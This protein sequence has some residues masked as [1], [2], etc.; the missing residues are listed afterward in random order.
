MR[1]KRDGKISLLFLLCFSAFGYAQIL[2][3]E[4]YSIKDGL[5]SNWITSIFQDS[6]GY[7]WIGGD[8]G[9]SVYDG[10]SFKT[11][12]V[13]DGLPIGFVW[14]FAE[15]RQSPGTIYVGTN[16]GGLSKLVN[17]KF[18]STL[19]KPQPSSAEI[20]HHNAVH[21]IFEDDEGR[22]WCG[23]NRG[24]YHIRGDSVSFF[25]ASH[26]SGGVLFIVQAPDGRI[27]FNAG[28]NLYTYSAKAQ[29]VE[30]YELNI[31]VAYFSS[32]FADDDRSVWIG[33]SRGIIYK[34]RDDRI[35]ASRQA[36]QSAIESI[37]GDREGFL[38]ITTHAGLLKIAKTDFAKG[39]FTHYTADNGLP[40]NVLEASF[41]DRENNLWL[42]SRRAGLHKL[43][44]RNLTTFPF[45]GVN[46]VPDVLNQTAATDAQNHL[47]VATEKGLWEIW[48]NRNGSWEKF[49]HLLPELAAR[50][51]KKSFNYHNS[52]AISKDGLLW[53][54]THGG[55]LAGYKL[56]R[57]PNQPSRLAFIKKLVPGRDLPEGNPLGIIIDRNNQLWYVIWQ[58]GIVQIDLGA[59]Q[60]R[61]DYPNEKAEFDGTPQDVLQDFEGRI[62]IGT[63][64]GGINIFEPEG[65]AYR[66]RRRLGVENGLVNGRVRALLQRRNG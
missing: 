58:Y 22:V 51:E 26:D 61:A 39:E 46:L 64:G 57:Q 37:V 5:S 21:A 8:G 10:I 50:T 31:G 62:W 1:N 12:G 43:S 27:W 3:F 11:F 45:A 23:T 25:F 28:G 40:D 9:L 41:I 49:I 66:L 44:E 52:V 17:G 30:R 15:S 29:A 33:T 53:H 7:L 56:T 38:W 24:V 32:F 36:S 34:I 19:L 2:P 42:G 18:S 60:M 35:V 65:G 47:F 13:D 59:L 16:G 20:S 54:V 48:K 14:C 4:H 6:R 55:G 63:F